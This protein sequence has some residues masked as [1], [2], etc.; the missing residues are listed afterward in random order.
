MTAHRGEMYKR[1]K[2]VV[3]RLRL[4]LPLRSCRVNMH[5]V[6]SRDAIFLLTVPLSVVF[7]S[8]TATGTPRFR[9]LQKKWET[10][11]LVR[12]FTIRALHFHRRKRHLMFLD[13][14]AQNETA[15]LRPFPASKPTARASHSRL[16]AC[17]VPCPTDAPVPL[18][19]LLLC[20]RV[21]RYPRIV[22]TCSMPI[23]RRLSLTLIILR[24]RSC[25]ATR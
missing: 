12:G 5:P 24:P 19:L 1:P 10:D 21:R 7:P 22:L 18:L 2:A 8:C 25:T 3:R 20:R 15:R 14:S 4:L 16:S 6:A 11:R 23:I 13:K 17:L 9:W